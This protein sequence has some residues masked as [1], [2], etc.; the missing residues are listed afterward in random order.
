ML[1]TASDISFVLS[2]GTSNLDP[3]SSIGG[4]PSSAPIPSGVLN[5]LFDDVSSGETNSGIE[6]YRCFYIFNDGETT[7]WNL[8]L[9]TDVETTGGAFIEIGTRSFNEK[10]RISILGSNGG[11]VVLS[12]RGR[13]FTTFYN[14]DA[15]TWALD[16]KEKLL[17]LTVSDDSDEK[18]FRDLNVLGTLTS[19]GFL[20]DISWLNKDGEQNLEKIVLVNN[21]LTPLE[22][23]SV[24]VS[25]IQN[26]EP[27]NT[28]SDNI[29]VDT[30]PPGGV[31]F[32]TASVTSPIS[33][34]RLA[35]TEGFPLWIKRVVPA[36]TQASQLDSITFRMSAQSM[37]PQTL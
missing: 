5:N 15:G 30:T 16:I 4:G 28:I 37:E 8:K 21:F 34:P 19:S 1:T 25:T 9:W 11:S 36:G 17:E 22:S 12:Y 3:N 29:E 31:N 14:S 27:I 20:F 6:D 23:T 18:I 10:Q 33:L 32:Y 26:G 2:G 13:E 7:V 24:I 35:P